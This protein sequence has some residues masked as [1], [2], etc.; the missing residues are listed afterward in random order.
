MS[1]CQHCAILPRKITACQACRRIITLRY[2]WRGGKYC[3][4]CFESKRAQ[5]EKSN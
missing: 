2:A 5:E 4:A 1:F 3:K